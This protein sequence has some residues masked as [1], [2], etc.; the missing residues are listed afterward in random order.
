MPIRVDNIPKELILTNQWVC[1]REIRIKDG[2]A[3]VPINPYNYSYAKVN[4]CNSWGNFHVALAAF[5]RKK[6]DGIGFVFS[7]D[8]PFIGVDLD[9]CFAENGRMYPEAN[10]IL[11]VLN[12]YTEISPSREGIHIIVK[13]P[14]LSL[15][16]E[17][18]PMVTKG[19][20]IYPRKRFF[21]VT[22]LVLPGS[23]PTIRER[24]FEISRYLREHDRMI[25]KNNPIEKLIPKN[26]EDCPLCFEYAKTG[27][28]ARAC[29]RSPEYGK[30]EQIA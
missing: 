10:R 18:P 6:A 4:D 2:V 22:S 30:D 17:L 11:N 5:A 8:D 12:S 21:T 14:V 19:F 29:A 28:H 13:S 25:K 3:K 9:G 23:E 16:K 20:E 15:K 7:D 27:V 26:T 1:W 24:H